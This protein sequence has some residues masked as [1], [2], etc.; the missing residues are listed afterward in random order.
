VNTT[1]KIALT[2]FV[3]FVSNSTNAQGLKD[4]EICEN[5]KNI[6][7]RDTAVALRKGCASAG[8]E[9]S[10]ADLRKWMYNRLE[11][12]YLPTKLECLASCAVLDA[13]D[14]QNMSEC[15]VGTHV[16]PFVEAVVAGTSFDEPTCEMIRTQ[17]T[18]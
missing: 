14:N 8:V 17:A 12:E 15:V 2:A 18:E 16:R 10:K 6:T 13:F 11:P 4:I 7:A 5:I 9:I 3:I 1:A